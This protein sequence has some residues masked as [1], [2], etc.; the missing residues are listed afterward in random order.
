[1]TETS[2][3]L[4]LSAAELIEGVFPGSTPTAAVLKLVKILEK[5]GPPVDLQTGF[6][7]LEELADWVRVGGA[8]PELDRGAENTSRGRT[9]RLQLVL[10]MVELHEPWK[11]D[12]YATMHLVL[13]Q[14]SA[15]RF[16]VMT[17]LSTADSFLGQAAE[18]VITTLLPQPPNDHDLGEALLRIFAHRDDVDWLDDFDPK[19]LAEL[20]LAVENYAQEH[21][22]SSPREVLRRCSIDAVELLSAR[23]TALGLADDV[24]IRSD[25]K[26]VSDS[27]FL[28]LARVVQ[29]FV[30]N[31][32]GETGPLSDLDE[33]RRTIVLCSQEL[34]SVFEHLDQHGV[35]VNLVYRLELCGM[36]L[37]RI[38][39]IA[40]LLADSS[41][42]QR[43]T[44]F[45]ARLIREGRLERSLVG[46]FKS[47]LHQLAK[48]IVESAGRSGGHYI[49]ATKQEHSKLLK[50]A[51]GGGVLTA[52]TTLFKFVIE[53]HKNPLFVEGLFSAF[54]Y[55]GSFL[56]MQAAGFT[57]ATKQPAMTA[58]TLASAFKESALLELNSLVEQVVRTARSQFAAALG[59]VGMVIPTV[60]AV[61]F[62]MLFVTGA[63]FLNTEKAD[64]I[65]G[66]LHP[67]ESWTI[68][69]AALTGAIL[70]FASVCGGWVL[71]WCVYHRLPEA[72]ATHRR[73][74]K[75][76][77][78]ER[79]QKFSM[80][81]AKNISGIS[82]NIVLGTLLAMIPIFSSF[83]GL[84]IQVR[85]VTLSA[86]ALTFA[87]ATGGTELL[88]TAD[89]WFAWLGVAIIG[90]LNFGVSFALALA[91]AVRSTAH[92]SVPWFALSW[93][94]VK[95]FISGP[96][97]FFRHPPLKT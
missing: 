84:S 57:L 72:F 36:M 26:D 51:A 28:T 34:Q 58:A 62:L 93:A 2:K 3:P 40:E 81:F 75:M 11:T 96:L 19:V 70:W 5:L 97:D 12:F 71:N 23:A 83:L 32:R 6:L 56:V 76:F 52:G 87:G 55:A 78:K 53:S 31:A 66:S 38:E 90:L 63:A 82:V 4:A 69:Y 10:K 9:E 17:G 33:I 79:M 37:E 60:I 30:N 91:L 73:L 43:I 49:A 77:G 50:S 54:N 22:K 16:M 65:V 25:T 15:R 74:S 86:G 24:L 35:S 7:W 29:G 18:H 88:L 61:H 95:R 14:T 21:E 27:P 1:M 64:Y 48:K 20:F 45:V 89:F 13:T 44:H 8:I 47:N 39:T 94:I 59:N 67:F 92:D 46:M 68:A 85:H 42:T 80:F 41:Q